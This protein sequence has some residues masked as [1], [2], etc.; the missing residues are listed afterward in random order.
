MPDLPAL[1]VRLSGAI[2]PRRA[3]ELARAAEA[4]GYACVCFG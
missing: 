1:S 2:A 3:V 4:A